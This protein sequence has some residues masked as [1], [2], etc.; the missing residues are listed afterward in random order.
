MTEGQ[1]A[2]PP[3]ALIDIDK[4]LAHVADLNGPKLRQNIHESRLY[5][6][7]QAIK[8]ELSTPGAF[9]GRA[10][11]FRYECWL[12]AKSF[13]QHGWRTEIGP[14]A[15]NHDQTLYRVIVYWFDN[16]EQLKQHLMNPWP[17]PETKAENRQEH[18][19]E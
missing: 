8:D 13:E 5:A 7:H 10:V 16:D 3:P 15:P 12:I 2:K 1:S 4:V 11:G 17:E 9:L 6:M 19:D 14:I 18:N